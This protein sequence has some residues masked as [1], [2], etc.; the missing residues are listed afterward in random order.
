MCNHESANFQFKPF[1]V[2]WEGIMTSKLRAGTPYIALAIM[3][4]A[5][6]LVASCRTD[7][8]EVPPLTGPSGARLFLTMEA[9]PDKIF[10]KTPNHV[11][12]ISRIVVQ[13]KD[14]LGHG[15]PNETIAFRIVNAE[16]S[17]VA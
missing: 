8:V 5:V 4:I 9:A 15:V 14:Q 3:A 6:L 16:G 2:Y 12:P 13:L 10:I 11:P 17:E 1:R 7:Q